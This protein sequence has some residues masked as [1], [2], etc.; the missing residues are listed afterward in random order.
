ML[1][2]LPTNSTCLHNTFFVCSRSVA[3]LAN[4]LPSLIPN[5]FI[6]CR[7]KFCLTVSIYVYVYVLFTIHLPACVFYSRSV[8]SPA[9]Q[10]PSLGPA[11]FVPYQAI[12]CYCLVIQAQVPI[13]I[14][15]SGE[16]RSPGLPFLLE[17]LV[18]CPRSG[19]CV[20]P[21]THTHTHLRTYIRT[22]YTYSHTHIH[23]RLYTHSHTPVH[24]FKDIF[25]HTFAHAYTHIRTRLYTH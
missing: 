16:S 18:M 24:T 22:L 10:L 2:V 4:Q 25:T 3:S 9:N 14:N 12:L 6:I 20:C 1:R 15:Q 11:R 23:T 19:V 21:N 17:T 5:W 7:Q 13:T 8:A